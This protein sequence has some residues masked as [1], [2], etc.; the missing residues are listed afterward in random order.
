MNC[1]LGEEQLRCLAEDQISQY[2]YLDKNFV[3]P[4]PPPHFAAEGLQSAHLE[5]VRAL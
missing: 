2:W 5:L 3:S 4:L 1:E